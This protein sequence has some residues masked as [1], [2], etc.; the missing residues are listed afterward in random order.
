M[1]EENVH[2]ILCSALVD[3]C[4]ERAK[5]I[6][7]GGAKYDWVSGLQVGI[8]NLGNSLAAVKKLVFDQGAIGQQELAKALAEDFDGLTHEQLRQRL[9]NGAPKYGND[10]DSVDG[11]AGAGLPDLYR[12]AEA[13][14]QPALLAAAQSAAT[15][16]LARRLSPPTFRSA[17]RRWRHRMAVKRTPRWR[18][19]PARPPVPTIWGRQRSSVRWANSPPARSS[20][21]CCLTRS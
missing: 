4:I 18:K 6:K 10:D 17:P 9:I 2:D 11:V 21:A 5:S 7:Q 20:A 15:I 13:V 12:R 8:A 19:G 14:S 1:L 16:T 3:D